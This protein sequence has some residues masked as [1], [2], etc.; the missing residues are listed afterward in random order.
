MAQVKKNSIVNL[1]VI[2]FLVVGIFV[3]GYVFLPE[4][5]SSVTSCLHSVDREMT[6]FKLAIED[7]AARM[8]SS[9]FYFRPESSCLSQLSNLSSIIYLEKLSAVCDKVCGFAANECYLL[10][11]SSDLP[12]STKRKCL[13][14]PAH[15][16]FE[17][18]NNCVDQNLISSGYS[19]IDPTVQGQLLVGQYI[20]RNVSLAGAPYPSI[21][22]WYKK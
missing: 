9:P 16:I 1:I 13:N 15:T 21:C 3:F 2:T 7:S 19:V 12:D 17:F 8:N 4:P 5:G 10:K 11:F 18:A 20:L 6:E 14:L 22:I